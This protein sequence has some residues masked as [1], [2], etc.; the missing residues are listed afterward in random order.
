MKA[1]ILASGEGQRLNP[2]TKTINKG[3]LLVAGKPVLKHIVE[4][5]IKSGLITEIVFAVGVKKEQVKSYFGVFKNYQIGDRR[6]GVDFFYAESDKAEG[7][8]GELFKARRFFENEE[9][10]L[11]HYGDAL[12]NLDIAEFYKQHRQNGR[13]ITS[14]GMKEIQT[15]SGVYL[16]KDGRVIGFWEKPFL[17]DIVQLDGIF[18]NVPIY[19]LNKRIWGSQNIS[20]GKDFNADIMPEFIRRGEVSIY[21]QPD[22]WHF[23][24]GDL[25]KYKQTCEAFESN[26]QNK[27]RKLS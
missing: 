3:M 8:A 4:N 9:D 27:L 24:I 22:L 20:P 25:K 15:E 13:V 14:P 5:I 7:T 21:Y 26:T 1:L 2:L 12:T 18:S 16:W 6:I 11:F 19:L 23:D 10:F 17:N